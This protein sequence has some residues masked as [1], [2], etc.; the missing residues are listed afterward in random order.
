[1]FDVSFDFV[2][3]ESDANPEIHLF[4]YALQYLLLLPYLFFRVKV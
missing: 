2:K 3:P 4:Y 1:M